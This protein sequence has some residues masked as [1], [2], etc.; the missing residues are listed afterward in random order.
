[1]LLSEPPPD[2]SI[3]PSISIN[4]PVIINE[5][6]KEEESDPNDSRQDE[7]MLK[8]TANDLLQKIINDP[9]FMEKYNGQ[10]I[11]ITG[12]FKT[13]EIGIGEDNGV[14]FIVGIG[15]EYQ[16]KLVRCEFRDMM[17]NKDVE[18]IRLKGIGT[19]ITVQTEYNEYDY[20]YF[21]YFHNC[22]LIPPK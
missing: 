18:T 13:G 3:S 4:E 15:P 22:T 1:M 14:V 17:L 2:E 7:G 10:V 11:Q 12:T 8:I 20:N 16:Y 21:H 5:P 9:N 19:E 6:V